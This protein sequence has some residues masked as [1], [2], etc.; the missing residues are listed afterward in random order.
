MQYE[1]I[2]LGAC[3]L[4]SAII[5]AYSIHRLRVTVRRSILAVRD[6]YRTLRKI[7]E[8]IDQS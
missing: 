4:I 3:I 5:V 7:L 6:E 8:I 1:I 2:I